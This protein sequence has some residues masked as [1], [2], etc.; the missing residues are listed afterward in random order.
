M[1][2]PI[3]DNELSVINQNL[4]NLNQSNSPAFPRELILEIFSHLNLS[5]LGSIFSVIKKWD[6]LGRELKK[7]ENQE[8]LWKMAIKK[9]IAFGNDK[10]AKYFGEEVIKDEDKQEEFSSLPWNEFIE[11]SKKFK[12]IFPNKNAKEILMLV[13]LPKSLN[14]CLNL[15]NLGKL[16]KKYFSQTKMGYRSIWQSVIA[17]LGDNSIEKSQW[18]LMTKNVLPGSGN[19][20]YDAQKAVVENLSEKGLKGYDMTRI[21]E[22]SVCIL[23]HYFD[24]KVFLFSDFESSIRCKE[25]VRNHYVVVGGFNSRGLFVSYNL[26]DDPRICVGAVRRF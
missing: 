3:K 16:S 23:A 12:I 5:S 19:K 17:V 20:G 8:N 11:D 7:L 13:R 6:S 9:D 18:V 15:K 14:G 4:G 25:I 2:L 26:F 24:S 22:S 21:L 1:S 10:W